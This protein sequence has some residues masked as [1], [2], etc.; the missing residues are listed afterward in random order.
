MS[1]QRIQRRR[2]KGWRA[3]M[4]A[5]YVG[6]GSKWGNPFRAN[7]EVIIVTSDIKMRHRQMTAFEAVQLYRLA[8]SV[9]Y[10]DDTP[11]VRN[12]PWN[13]DIR[14]ELAGHDLMCW[15]PLD[16]PCHADVLLELANEGE[17]A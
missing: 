3:P 8:L 6:R 4:G 7:E 16:Q 17:P 1:P 14:R 12:L 2:T 9:R 11:N 13:S 5:I 15:C 10:Y